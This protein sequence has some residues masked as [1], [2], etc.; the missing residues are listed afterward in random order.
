VSQHYYSRTNN[1]KKIDSEIE[2]VFAW[3]KRNVSDHSSFHYLIF[4]FR[5]LQKY[6]LKHSSD[7][8]TSL[9]LFVV[10]LKRTIEQL[11]YCQFM[12]LFYPAHE[13]LWSYRKYLFQ[14]LL[15]LL[16][17]EFVSSNDNATLSQPFLKYASV[18][19]FSEFMDVLS[20]MSSKQ[21]R[22]DQ[23]FRIPTLL[24]ELL[25]AETCALD[26]DVSDYKQ[27]RHFALTY[28]VWILDNVLKRLSN[29]YSIRTLNHSL[30]NQIVVTNIISDEVLQSD[31]AEEVYHTE[32][33]NKFIQV[34]G[35][36][37]NESVTHGNFWAAKLNQIDD[38]K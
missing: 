22:S 14:F 36:L 32:L 17:M 23:P 25:F 35:T 2:R 10:L 8:E 37:A 1:M 16:A 31:K 18:D 33:N 24:N 21:Y 4:L 7:T 3:T 11:H 15:D 20:A 27:Q 34:V 9:E 28:Q 12:I 38:N 13:S 29:N 5:I 6:I 26:T 30:L 19:N